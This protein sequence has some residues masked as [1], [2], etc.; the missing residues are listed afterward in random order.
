MSG[1]LEFPHGAAIVYLFTAFI[2]AYAG[3]WNMEAEVIRSLVGGM[4]TLYLLYGLAMAAVYLG[5][6]EA[7][8]VSEFLWSLAN[9]IF[10]GANM[11]LARAW[12]GENETE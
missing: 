8:E 7:N 10:G 6:G 9:A 11:L 1:V 3:L 2:F 4:G 5:W 12:S